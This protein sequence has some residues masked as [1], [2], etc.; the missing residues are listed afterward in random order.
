[1][2]GHIA[3]LALSGIARP[4]VSPVVRVA[5]IATGSEMVG[6]DEVPREAQIRD[7]N[8]PMI[9]ALLQESHAERRFHCRIDESPTALE[10]AIG[11]ALEEGVHLLLVSGGASVGE[12][13]HTRKVLIETGFELLVE[14]INSRPGK[15]LIVAR[16]D[17]L[18]A[19]GLP[20]NPLSHFVCY[21]LFVHRAI[22]RLTGGTPCALVG[23]KAADVSIARPR[24]GERWIPCRVICE[25]ATVAVQA[26]PS[27][28]SSDL[29]V[30]AQ[31]R[32]LLRVPA[33]GFENHEA[34][35]FLPT[36]EF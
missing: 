28:D 35:E 7:T 19:F 31:A 15:P 3:L 25:N 24:V 23:A 17:G 9:S 2:P 34:G 4:L 11:A 30:L 10:S 22:A 32:G 26:L 1:M 29:T 36:G 14:G 27:Q 21:H 18:I 16:K 13:D 8:S 20:G 12:H 5:H 6:Y 33:E